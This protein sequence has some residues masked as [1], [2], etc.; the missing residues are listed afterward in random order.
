[1][2][3]KPVIKIEGSLYTDFSGIKRLFNFYHCANEYSNTTIFI[4]FFDLDWFDANLSA[5]LGAILYKLSSENN[6]TF[7]TDLN[8]L[9]SKF[10]VLFRNGFLNSDLLVNDDRQS[11]VAFQKFRL[12]DKAGFVS[13]I[14]RDLMNHRGIPSLSIEQ[15]DSIIES[16]IEVYCNIQIHSKS[17]Y[18]FFVCGQ[19]YPYQQ[20]L[21]FTMLDLGVGFLPAIMEKT[22][23]QVSNSYEAIKWSLIKKNTTKINCP[24]GIG[25]FNLN[26]YFSSSGGDMQI[27][28]GDTFW[29]ISMESTVLGKHIF[30]Q[31]FVGSILNLCFS[32]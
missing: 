13:Y 11:T 23:G 27:I 15:K 9:K 28:T 5:I 25:L 29:S 12:D 19:Y 18:D 1:M 6:L 8:F 26:N 3:N 14:E 21:V 30:L 32:V 7:S 22:K 10:D 4:D 24:G 31:P 2:E 16:L 17:N 20:K